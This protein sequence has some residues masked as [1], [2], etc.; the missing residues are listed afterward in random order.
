MPRLTDRDPTFRHHKASG[1]AVVT[2]AGQDAYLGPHGTAA[3][4]REYDRV[5]SASSPPAAAKW[6]RR[7]T[8]TRWPC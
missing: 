6:L 3:S 1:Q 5:A 7:R 4:R 8:R 2:L